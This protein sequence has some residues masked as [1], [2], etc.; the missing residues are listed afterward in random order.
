MSTH[1]KND[2]AA[3][4]AEGFTTSAAE[5]ERSTPVL[6]IQEQNQL[7]AQ[8]VH[9][10]ELMGYCVHVLKSLACKPEGPELWERADFREIRECV[11][12]IKSLPG[13]FPPMH[14]DRLPDGSLFTGQ[15]TP[16]PSL[17]PGYIE[18][19][20]DFKDMTSFEFPILHV[21]AEP[22]MS[23]E[24]SR[25]KKSINAVHFTHLRLR[26]GS[27]DV[28]V[29]RLSMS[30]AHD[31][32]RL[33]AG[34]IIELTMATPLTFRS[35]GLKKPQRS[36]IVVI[37][38]FQRV[39]Y[40]AV[41]S[42]ADLKSP[43][44]CADLTN[45]QLAESQILESVSQQSANT[46]VRDGVV[47]ER[48]VEVECSP[49][50]RYC[51][52]YGVGTVICVCESDPV[53]KLDLE[54]IHQYCWFATMEAAKMDNGLKRNMLY[55]WYMTNT[56]SICGKGQ[57]ADPPACLKAAIR[58]AYPSDD[59]WYKAFVEAGNSTKSRK[60]KKQRKKS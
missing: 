18:A 30:L 6:S 59:G 1:K 41:P 49:E 16:T 56:Y 22:K 43:R 54:S 32:K 48:L 19:I 27:N 2:D 38:N 7:A 40:V 20:S 23:Y 28:I 3:P 17:T 14:G 60:N 8:R 35:S 36:P 42:N 34:D 46:C 13:K 4:Q 45:A 15:K 5:P 53:E 9:Q 47:F 26:D 39:G 52:M 44:H 51:S 25:N 10:A 12:V 50:H 31:G 55:W 33:S 58:K 57:R 24:E 29:G 37:H 11:S 21:V